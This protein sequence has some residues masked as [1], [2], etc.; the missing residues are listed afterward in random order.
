[1]TQVDSWN[2][3]LNT[4]LDVE[5][6]EI[7]KLIQQEK[8]RQYSGLELIASEVSPA[9]WSSERSQE[10]ETKEIGAKGAAGQE[11]KDWES[12]EPSN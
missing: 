4:P 11:L 9:F 10:K 1:M 8:Y 7:Y 6:P 2:A 12:R 3:G 5:D